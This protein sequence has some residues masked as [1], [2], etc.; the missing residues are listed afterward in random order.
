MKLELTLDE[1]NALISLIDI[2]VKAGGL[3][4]A[5]TAVAMMQKLKDA[6]EKKDSE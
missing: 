3:Q 1:A 5:P 2:A 6:A 4:V